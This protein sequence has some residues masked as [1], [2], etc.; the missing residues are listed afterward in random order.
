M[1]DSAEEQSKSTS[2]FGT[3]LY[4]EIFS[5]KEGS[6][7][8]LIPDEMLQ[9]YRS[10]DSSS[11]SSGSPTVRQELTHEAQQ[12]PQAALA[13]CSVDEQGRPYP[14]RPLN[15]RETGLAPGNIQA[16][17]LKLLYLH[18][19]L[20]ATEFSR[21]LCL[22]FSVIDESLQF[23]KDEKCVMVN[24]AEQLGRV[25]YEYTL[26]ELG[27]L[28]AREAFDQCKYIGP[29]PVPIESYIELCKAQ[30]V[31]GSECS[32][33]AL[34][35]AFSQLVIS[36]KLLQQLG[37]AVCSGRSI[38][39]YGPPGNG[40][41]SI[42]KGLGY[43]LNA[44]GGD[45]Y[46]PYAIEA[47]GAIIT[48]FDPT[49]HQLSQQTVSTGEQKSGLRMLDEHNVDPR[50]RRIRRPVIITGGEL[51][52][53]MLELRY[54]A[55]GNYYQA[56][57][58][59]KANG[60]VFLLDDFGRQLVS[61]K[62]LLNRWILPLEERIDFLTL[63]TGKKITVPFEQMIIFSTNLDPRELVDEAFLRRIRH[64]I[65]ISSP[66][67][68]LFSQI[69]QLVCHQNNT[70]FCPEAVDYLFETYYSQGKPPRSSDP[71]DL[72]EIA[73]SICRYNRQPFQLSVPLI[74][75]SS[76]RFFCEL[77]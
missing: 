29:A 20:P 76:K 11:P 59:V 77:Y 42:A 6:G 68:E 9:H 43:F 38:F 55:T 41:S 74:A 28:R 3:D 47:D 25:T 7:S 63:V 26:T 27:R 17:E 40:K 52:L 54:D 34:R 24:K 62:D 53:E 70:A 73:E 48:M 10:Q 16:L 31:A 1:Y 64:K 56:P 2:L 67:K 57:M 37:P 39:I 50:W 22:P 44:H 21:H 51:S 18:G 30:A 71:R 66:D 5:G 69:F 13:G 49:V 8:V 32:A 4:A 36:P 58:H 45:I 35:E 19:I 60:G 75:E 65:P 15:L 12:V 46:I 23:L 14:T 33:E 72:V 61:P